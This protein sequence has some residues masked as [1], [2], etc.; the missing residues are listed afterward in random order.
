MDPH[1]RLFGCE[2][3][4]RGCR[5]EKKKEG[6][7]AKTC[8]ALSTSRVIPQALPTT[9]LH[10]LTRAKHDRGPS[11]ILGPRPLVVHKMSR[12]VIV[13]DSLFNLSQLQLAP[14]DHFN[15]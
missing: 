9:A 15:A 11:P 7:G 5:A 14:D 6:G 12:L 13:R 1:E 10:P 8:F 4:S 2:Q 3:L